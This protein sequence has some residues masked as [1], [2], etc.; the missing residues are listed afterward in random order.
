MLLV[1]TIPSQDSQPTKD[2]N[3]AI[4]PISN[5]NLI[6]KPR[7]SEGFRT[8]HHTP[9]SQDTFWCDTSAY[10]W[11]GRTLPPNLLPFACKLNN[12]D[13][14]QLWSARNERFAVCPFKM[15][16]VTAGDKMLVRMRVEL[17][18]IA[19]LYLPV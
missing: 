4:T 14:A 16:H 9:T 7:T 11:H 13:V 5:S 3:I 17:L 8:L 6:R 18:F 1:V 10:Y 2:Q 12:D 15:S 19:V